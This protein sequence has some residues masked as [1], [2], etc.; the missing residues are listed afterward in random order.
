MD[1]LRSGIGRYA[2]GLVSVAL[3]LQGCG[4]QS[5]PK[6]GGV[7]RQRKTSAVS[8][9][10]STAPAPFHGQL[11]ALDAVQFVTPQLGVAAGQG[12]VL[13]T[14]DG[15]SSWVQIYQGQDTI[16]SVDFTGQSEGW[17]LTQGGSLLAWNGKTWA[18]VAA[19]VGPLSAAHLFPSG[20]G[21]IVTVGG[22]TYRATS[23]SGPWQRTSLGSVAAVSFSG[24]TGWAVTASPSAAPMV[25][26][27]EDEGQTWTQ[28]YTPKLGQ[29]Q[30][31]TA[32]LAASG[33]F[34]WL[35]LT[36]AGGQMEHQPY[37]A[38]STSN[39]GQQWSEQVAAPLFVGQ[40]LYPGAPA[41]L[42]GLKAGPF[43][44]QGQ[45]AYFLSWAP[46]STQRDLALSATA[47]GG[48]TWTQMSMSQLNVSDY[49]EFFAPIAM[50]VS[51]PD[52]IWIVGSRGGSGR[53]L[54]SR[55]GGVQWTAPSF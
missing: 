14:S 49:P 52:T 38:Y 9:Q 34:A 46:N 16:R 37:V 45:Q 44:V 41:A 10:V 54:V 42:V 19:S 50:A 2:V 35:L 47:D 43:A 28:S 13:E 24:T 18:E 55:D 17:A 48:A 22:E 27:T 40:G 20:A 6:A 39:L 33:N 15:G 3:L 5:H 12:I 31:W 36:Y 4:T 8:S 25:W 21:L 26:A 7:S 30:G 32:S 53:I 1:G 23:T 11:P 51:V 29:T